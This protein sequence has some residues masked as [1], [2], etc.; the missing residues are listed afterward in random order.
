[1]IPHCYSTWYFPN[2]YWTWL[3]FPVLAGHVGNHLDFNL[4]ACLLVAPFRIVVVFWYL[5]SAD[6][7]CR[8][9]CPVL[10]W[11]QWWC[12]LLALA[13]VLF[14]Y[15]CCF[16]LWCP[17]AKLRNLFSLA[18]ELVFWSEFNLK[19]VFLLSSVSLDISGDSGSK[20]LLTDSHF[21]Y[22]CLVRL[23]YD[24]NSTKVSLTWNA[25]YRK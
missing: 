25:S 12:S 14:T 23:W 9:L 20:A 8:Q 3:Y 19:I 11:M 16:S 22:Q 6:H 1:M 15:R 24:F 4:L 21:S 7:G 13:L 18:W 2:K 5:C 10:E 17:W